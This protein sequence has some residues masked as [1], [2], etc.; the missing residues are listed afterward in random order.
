M[1]AIGD[2]EV[3]TQ[4]PVGE[5]AQMVHLSDFQ[6]RDFSDSDFGRRILRVMVANSVVFNSGVFDS[7]VFDSKYLRKRQGTCLG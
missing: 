7:G 4:S 3:L 1:F 2:E 6:P 5:R